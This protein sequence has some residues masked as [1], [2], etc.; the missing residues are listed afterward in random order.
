METAAR[1]N[2][3]SFK[4]PLTPPFGFRLCALRSEKKAVKEVTRD[5]T[6]HMHKR[7]HGV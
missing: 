5:Y 4:P 3:H 6:V 2:L 7:I 1:N